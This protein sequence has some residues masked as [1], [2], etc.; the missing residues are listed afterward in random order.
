MLRLGIKRK[1]HRRDDAQAA[2][3]D[4]EFAAVRHKALE[5]SGYRCVDCGYKSQP[6]GNRGDVGGSGSSLQV[7][8]VNDDHSD[9]QEQNLAGKSVLCH[10]YHHVGCDA[11]SSG[12][13]GGWSSQMRVAYAP[14]L[15]PSDMNLLQL[16]VGVAMASGGD[17][18]KKAAQAIYT[19]LMLLTRPVVDGWG[20]SE[21]KN[22][23]AAMSRL[24]ES[25]Y[26]RRRVNDL[27]LV[28]H[29]DLLKNQAG[30][31]LKDYAIMKPE[32]WA[33]LAKQ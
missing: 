26:E 20:T 25:Q 13:H 2:Q 22:F 33:S 28:F 4:A 21:A 15:P 27:R 30:N 1:T 11:E 14:D 17:A 12:G 18:Q 6:A 19:H 10:A 24:S 16:A 23:A 8:H 29:P 9:N 3:A 32:A 7:H 31:W 5:R